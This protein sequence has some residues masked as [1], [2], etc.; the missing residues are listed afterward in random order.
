MLWKIGDFGTATESNPEAAPSTRSHRGTACYRAPELIREEPLYTSKADI[1][2]LGCIL[3]ELATRKKAFMGDWKVDEYA[4]TKQGPEV[5]VPTWPKDF[6]SHLSENV[7]ELLAVDRH[8]RPFTSVV[9]VT[10]NSYVRVLD[11][12]IAPPL[13]NHDE[14]LPCYSQWKQLVQLPDQLDLGCKLTVECQKKGDEEAAI[15]VWKDLVEKNSSQQSLGISSHLSPYP[16]VNMVAPAPDE[17]RDDTQEILPDRSTQVVNAPGQWQWSFDR[18]RKS[19]ISEVREQL[20][21]TKPSRIAGNRQRS[22]RSGVGAAVL[23]PALLGTSVISAPS[24][25][26][27]EMRLDPILSLKA[28]DTESSFD[29]NSDN[30]NGR[31]ASI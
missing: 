19:A 24:S 25:P 20:V 11:P 21:S 31:P 18:W 12:G 3:Y 9:R 10:F 8:E 16:A 4:K 23:V 22:S 17:G 27:G 7:Q 13:M 29:S 5:C 30:E 26:R 28:T 6:Q 1:W 14:S 2:G 15:R